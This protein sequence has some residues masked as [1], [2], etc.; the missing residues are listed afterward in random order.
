MACSL[1]EQNAENLLFDLIEKVVKFP[2]TK[3]QYS[4]KIFYFKTFKLVQLQFM[5]LDVLPSFLVSK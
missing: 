4:S 3:L 1:N 2:K 5:Y